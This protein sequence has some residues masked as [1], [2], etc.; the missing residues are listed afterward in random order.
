MLFYCLVEKFLNLLMR[1]LSVLDGFYPGGI[2]IT[3]YL[4]RRVGRKFVIEECRFFRVLLK[5]IKFQIEVII[6]AV[7]GY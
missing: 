7:R 3:F 1:I 2:D 5:K 4:L 6:E